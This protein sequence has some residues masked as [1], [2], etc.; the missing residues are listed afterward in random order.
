MRSLAAPPRSTALPTR[1]ESPALAPTTTRRHDQSFAR[2]TPPT[3][4]PPRPSSL[5]TTRL[6]ASP[7]RSLP[8]TLQLRARQR[9]NRSSRA[10]RRHRGPLTILGR[11]ATRASSSSSPTR[12]R[13]PRH[14]LLSSHPL[15]TPFPSRPWA[16][17]RELRGSRRVGLRSAQ[18]VERTSSLLG[19]IAPWAITE[20]RA[21]FFLSQLDRAQYHRPSQLLLPHPLLLHRR[22]PSRSSQPVL[23]R[24]LLRG[25]RSLR[26]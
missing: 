13:S 18:A 9:T 3:S 26:T 22:T 4:P 2:S 23:P 8:P 1:P 6:S 11:P 20:H 21:H 16:T 19:Q 15:P 5:S 12:R 24:S 14:P 17:K 7:T 10:A 25:S